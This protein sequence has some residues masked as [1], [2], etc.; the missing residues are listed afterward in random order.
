MYEICER[1]GTCDVFMKIHTLSAEYINRNDHLRLEVIPAGRTAE[2]NL[3]QGCHNAS[4]WY[5]VMM[6]KN[7]VPVFLF[8]WD[9]IA[10]VQHFL[11]TY[12]LASQARCA[13]AITHDPVVD[14]D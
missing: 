14:A 8:K 2:F 3:T 11:R 13:P 10:L 1:L 9:D 6:K 7:F 4:L 5:P 12:F